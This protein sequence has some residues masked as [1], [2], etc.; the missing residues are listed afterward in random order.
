MSSSK[1]VSFGSQPNLLT[2][3]RSQQSFT[4]EGLKYLE[5]I[6]T[7]ILFVLTSIPFSFI[8]SPTH[9]ICI[10]T[11]LKAF[12]KFFTLCCSPVAIPKSSG[13]PC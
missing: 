1:L 10:D 4:S 3:L 12:Y 11:I 6:S 9:L 13:V 2:A 5:S 8:P 7:N